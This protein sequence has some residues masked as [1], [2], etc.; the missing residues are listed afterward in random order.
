MPFLSGL[1]PNL[2]SRLL[3]GGLAIALAIS[4]AML[5]DEQRHSAK[6][7]KRAGEWQAAHDKLE[8]NIRAK[9]ALAQAQD[10]AHAAATEARDL[11]KAMETN[12]ALRKDIARVNALLAGW[13]RSGAPQTDPRRGSGAAV[14]AS[15]GSTPRLAGAGGGA[16]IPENDLRICAENTLKAKAARE[17]LIGLGR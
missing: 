11:K 7:E 9:T 4:C 15:P 2:F 8:A 5:W 3:T 16:F 1:L 14:P 12:D 6:W 13:L 17:F 10:A